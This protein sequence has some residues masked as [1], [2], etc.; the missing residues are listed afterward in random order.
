MAY[1]N[2]R[3]IIISQFVE[4]VNFNN[5]NISENYC[6]DINIKIAP[7]PYL[8]SEVKHIPFF[9]QFFLTKIKVK[10]IRNQ[11][12]KKEIKKKHRNTSRMHSFRR[13]KLKI[14][15]MG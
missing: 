3:K 9:K 13:S 8:S 4:P 14:G 6:S 1:I 11:S 15:A 12:K 7:S 5:T 10:K 2:K